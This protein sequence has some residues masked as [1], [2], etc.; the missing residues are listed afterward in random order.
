ML[1]DRPYPMENTAAE[2]PSPSQDAPPPVLRVMSYNVQVGISSS[3]PHHYLLHSWKHVLPHTERLHNIE[4]LARR[5]HDY[6]IVGLQEVD[7][8][9]LR[10]NF[11]NLTEYMAHVAGFPYWHH[12]VNRNLGHVARHSNGLLSRLRPAEIHDLKLPGMIPGRRAILACYGGGDEPLAVFILHL[13]LGRRARASQLDYLADM[14]NEFPHAIVMGDFN[15]AADS[16]EMSRLFAR[17]HLHEPLEEVHTFPSWRPQRHI[18]HILVSSG[19]TV[20]E[21]GVPALPAYSDHLPIAMDIRLPQGL[22]R[23]VRHS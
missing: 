15:C 3:R 1:T 23:S 17:T 19:L 2:A 9:S 11:I 22:Q 10:S 6:D 13:A 5:L 4:Q 18:D 12:Q 14:V 8:G 7:A 16:P 20:D 21:L